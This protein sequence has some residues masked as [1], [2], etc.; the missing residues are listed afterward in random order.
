MLLF[1][2]C[3]SWGYEPVV[4]SCETGEGVEQV[5]RALEVRGDVWGQCGQGRSTRVV[6]GT[7]V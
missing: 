2:P 4:L 5:A 7:S 3:R 6:S 1:A